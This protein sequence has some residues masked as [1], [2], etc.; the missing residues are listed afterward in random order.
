MLMLQR[1][2][3]LLTTL[4]NPRRLLLVIGIL[5]V[6]LI[7]IG[8]TVNVWEYTN[9]SQFCGTTCHTMPPEYTAYKISP[10]ARVACVECHLGRDA[11]TV[12]FGRK[13]GDMKHV[14]S[15]IAQQYETPI[16]A[17]NMRPARD[18]CEKCHW[19]EKF[20]NDSLR[21]IKHYDSDK[22]NTEHSTFLVM[23]TG[24]GTERE[25]RGRGIHWHIENQVWY[26]SEDELKQE[27]PWVRVVDKKGQVTDYVDVEANITPEQI[28]KAEKKLMDCIDCH[29]RVSHLFRSPQ[30]AI[31][32]A[33]ATHRIDKKIPFIKRQAV[34]ILNREYESMAAA[35]K[36]IESLDSLY[37]TSYPDFYAANPDSVAQAIEVLKEIYGQIVFPTMEVGWNTHPDNI[38]HKEWPGCFRCHDGKHISQDGGSIRLHCNICHSIPRTVSEGEP[39]PTI[40]MIQEGEPPSHLATNWMAEHRFQA[41]VDC[42]QCHGEHTFGVDNKNFCSNSNCHGTKW[43]WVGLDAAFP[44]P[45]ALVGKHAALTCNQCHAKNTKPEYSCAQCHTKPHIFG[46]ERCQDCHTP[47]GFK[48]SAEKVL[49]AAPHVPHSLD[50][51]QNC[52]ACHS[53]GTLQPI[54]EDHTGRPNETCLQCHVVEP[55]QSMEIS[56]SKNVLPILQSRCAGCHGTS[57]GLKVTTYASLMA[58]GVS[59]SPIKPNDPKGSLLIYKQNTTHKSPP[60]GLAPDELEIIK[61]WIAAGAPNN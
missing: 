39:A 42:E 50:A 11:F 33:I 29:N 40:S 2:R 26:I 20:S 49:A 25:G 36:A 35:N 46:S 55:V 17:K 23:R 58:G 15:L 30:R 9:S 31:D 60:R 10:H 3:S 28:Q 41:N 45:V 12:I 61:R 6:G 32:E 7:S 1:L 24:G 38:G 19:P 34:D 56:F 51:R 47:E 44:H 43:T 48:Q 52:L 54:P 14:I 18:S 8:A 5:V 53:P 21:V 59:G 22:D 57:A 13:A 16:H 37:K 27:I 4:R